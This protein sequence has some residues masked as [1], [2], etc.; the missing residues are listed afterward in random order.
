[1]ENMES[2]GPRVVWAVAQLSLAGPPTRGLERVCDSGGCNIMG[3]SKNNG[4]FNRVFHFFHHPFWDTPSFGN[5]HMV[6]PPETKMPSKKEHSIF[7]PLFLRGRVSF[8]G[9]C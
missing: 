9:T 7:Q 3:V 2:K 5:I 8:P 4:H 1:M 6:T